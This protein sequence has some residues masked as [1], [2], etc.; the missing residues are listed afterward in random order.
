MREAVSEVGTVIEDEYCSLCVGTLNNTVS[1][2]QVWENFILSQIMGALVF[3][4]I[5]IKDHSVKRFCL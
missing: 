2:K 4:P 3:Q 5:K 1:G